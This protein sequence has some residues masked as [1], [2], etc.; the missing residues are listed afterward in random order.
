MVKKIQVHR[1]IEMRL[2]I[3]V[4]PYHWSDREIPSVSPAREYTKEWN[5]YFFACMEDAGFKGIEP[6]QRG[7][8]FVDA[9]SVVKKELRAP[10]YSRRS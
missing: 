9:F 1:P 4:E 3:E 8:R 7:S 10:Y 2:V 5:E 6:I